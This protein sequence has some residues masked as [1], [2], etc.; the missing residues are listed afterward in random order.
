MKMKK[1]NQL[2]KK[3]KISNETKIQIVLS[4]IAISLVIAKIL[5][6][7]LSSFSTIGYFG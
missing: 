6:S 3:R 4:I 5:I 1:K 7:G 2:Y